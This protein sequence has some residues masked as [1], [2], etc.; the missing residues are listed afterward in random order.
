L[1]GTGSHDV[2]ATS[3]RV[4]R[5]R[6]IMPFF[7]PAKFDGPLFRLPF[8]TLLASFMSGFPLGVARRALDE[9]TALAQKKSRTIPPGPT[10]A[11]DAAIQVELAR[12]EA[13]VRSARAFVI[14][15][16]GAGWEAV[17]A[18]DEVSLSQR[19]TIGLATLNAARTARTSVDSVFTMAGGGALYDSS[20][21]QRCVR[22]LMAG[23]QHIIFSMNQW[24]TVGRVFL[25][26]D[27]ASFTL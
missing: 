5:E 22:D 10:M 23:T 16:I 18:G 19:A 24:K 21:L 12:A 11:E 4:P 13:A 6:T 14:E 25:G 26:L 8:P 2:T 20:P 27:P 9:F 1:R 15:S 3:V 17:S 7:E